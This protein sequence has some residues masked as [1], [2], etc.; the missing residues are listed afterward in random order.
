M[1]I[2]EDEV[3]CVMAQNVQYIDEF[4]IFYKTLFW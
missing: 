2:N 4:D 1:L 3:K